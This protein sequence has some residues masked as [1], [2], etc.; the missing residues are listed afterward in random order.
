[1]TNIKSYVVYKT[2]P[3]PMTLNDLKRSIQLLKGSR[4]SVY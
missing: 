3:L 4:Q 1:M 2:A